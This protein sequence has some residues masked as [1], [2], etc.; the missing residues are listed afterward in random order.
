MGGA[1]FSGW[2]D[3]G[4]D[5]AV[6]VTPRPATLDPVAVGISVFSKASEIPDT[7]VPSVVVFAMKPQYAVDVL[8]LYARYAACGA[9]FLSIMAGITVAGLQ[10]K[11]GGEAHV[12]RAMPNTPAA[13]RKGFTCMFAGNE[14]SAAKRDLCETLL[15]AVGEVAWLEEESL[16]D[17]ATAIS[18]GGPAYVFL[19][20]EL[21]EAAALEQGL[22]A[23]VAAR[24]ARATVSG[25]GALLASSKL[26]PAQLRIDVTSPGG[27]TEQALRLLMA[28]DAWPHLVS[29]AIG[30]ASMRSRALSNG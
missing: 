4:L 1:L 30:A 6:I 22:P 29:E 28:P 5:Q 9:T 20:T 10:S 19:L 27:T 2:I 23:T 18:G 24:M 7:F 12:V 17:P 11:V 21:L 16:L 8:P 14:V 25:S 13:I 3:R 26:S 15:A